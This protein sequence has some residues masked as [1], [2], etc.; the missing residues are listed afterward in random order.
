[1]TGA[2]TA[3][4]TTATLRTIIVDDDRD[5]AALHGRFVAAH[6]AFTV[7]GL[8]HSGPGALALIALTRPDLVLLDFHLPGLSGLEVLRDVRALGGVQPEVIAVTAA[9][10][11]DSVRTARSAG[12]LHYLVKPFTAASLQA[13]L[14][15]V[16][17]DRLSLSQTRP[18]AELAQND[19]DSI[20]RS[21]T[22]R[23]K[24]P[25]KGLSTA[26]LEVVETALERTPHTSASELAVVCGLSRVSVRR[27][28]EF[29]VDC[30]RARQSLY[31]G[32]QGRP[33]ARYTTVEV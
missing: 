1:M 26:T 4:G 7:V 20:L 30:G 12:V 14:D 10:D 11:V 15:D 25:P 19:I 22:G 3:T 13:R 33:S 21:R 17:R 31:Y 24:R 32:T 28:L 6:P 23:P 5:V 27:Y 16:A 8:A 29:L 9:R 2:G 18:A